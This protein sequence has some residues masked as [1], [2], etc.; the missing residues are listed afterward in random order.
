M[1]QQNF[2]KKHETDCLSQVI[3][4]PIHPEEQPKWL[5]LMRDNHY[6]GF[7]KAVGRRIF[8]VAILNG[9]WLAL[10]SWA[11]AALHIKCRDEWI[12]W[13]SVAKEKRLHQ[14]VN[15]TRFLI[16]PGK[17]RQNLASRLLALN[18]QRLAK[19]W[20]ERYQYP[21]LLAETF[22]DPAHYK[23]TCYLAQ[24]WQLIGMTEGFGHH[25]KGAYVLHGQPKKVLI[26]PLVKNCTQKLS[27]PV[28]LD[29]YGVKR[30]LLDVSKLPMGKSCSM[31]ESVLRVPKPTSAEIV[32][33][34][35]EGSAALSAAAM[36]GSGR[37]AATGS[38]PRW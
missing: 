12:G 38:A 5:E 37:A 31:L 29:P 2:E 17:K 11:A 34:M 6:L 22:V 25:P 19:D 32:S 16:L 8:Y 21:I 27:L 30:T 24:G 26:Y 28:F 23:G 13:D 20:F 4:R 35:R 9:K 7:G 36:T 10:L 15:N 3:V 1:E 14:V 33:S 18:L